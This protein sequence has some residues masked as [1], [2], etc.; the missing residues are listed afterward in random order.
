MMCMDYSSFENKRL[1]LIYAL[2]AGTIDKTEFLSRSYQLFEGAIYSEPDV[3]T[4]IEQ[5]VFYYFYFNT[6]AKTYMKRS[7]IDSTGKSAYISN[8][9]YQIKES[10]LISLIGLFNDEELSTYYVKTDSVKLKNKLVEI[11]VKSREKLIF[12]TLNPKT[13]SVL[14]RRGLLEP[15]LQNSAISSYINKKYY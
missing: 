13:I 14:K 3:I 1:E 9:Y 2:E 4:S 7:R 8:E 15:R 6:M 5:G 12:H 11:V 10:V